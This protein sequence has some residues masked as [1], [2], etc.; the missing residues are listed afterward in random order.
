MTPTE[1]KAFRLRHGISQQQAARLANVP[2]QYLS[3][4]ETFDA[5]APEIIGALRVYLR[6]QRQVIEDDLAAPLT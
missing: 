3:A 2:V 6:D 1:L 5:R 4:V